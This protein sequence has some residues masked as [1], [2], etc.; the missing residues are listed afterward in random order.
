M[1]LTY[2]F[3]A[4]TIQHRRPVSGLIVAEDPEVALFELKKMGLTKADVS[5]N[6]LETLSTWLGAAP[7]QREL[8]RFY[9]TLGVRL[10]NQGDP[11]EAVTGGLEYL[12]DERL[13][14]QVAIFA[15]Q[16][17]EG[18]KPADAMRLAKFDERECM[19]VGAYTTAGDY[20]KA[21]AN[22]SIEIADRY[23]LTRSI[24]GMLRMPQI[25]V[26]LVWF[27]GLPGVFLGLA[28]NMMKFLKQ[29]GSTLKIP[30]SI[31][32]FYAFVGW[33]QEN[34]WPTLGLY[35]GIPALVWWVI[36][37]TWFKNQLDRIK[38]VHQL[39]VRNDHAM[40]WG[41]YSVLDRAGINPA[42]TCFMLSKSAA[43]SDTRDSLTIMGR[44]L[45]GGDNDTL[46]IAAAKFP[47][48]VVS[49]FLAA[50]SSGSLPDGLDRFV[51][52]LKDDIEILTQKLSDI[53]DLTSKV[54]MALLVLALAYVVLYPA[55]GPVLSNL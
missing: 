44:R 5:L 16:L 32:A 24:K 20:G 47:G 55:I 8:A 21:F 49:Q 26:S 14:T 29:G 2:R 11:V 52:D 4:Q 43:R 54:L 50:R 7:D 46:A 38:I 12:D 42:E 3:K 28:P 13:K 22:L 36:Q 9:R 1:K 53:A 39:S 6:P 37:S 25:M 19:V 41:A 34:S 17:A 10:A 33:T 18:H 40:L 48:F 30:D 27:A 31:Q 23:R 15:A 35:L 45:K 51:L